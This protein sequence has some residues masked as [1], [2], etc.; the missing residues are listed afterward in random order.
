MTEGKFEKYLITSYSTR[1]FA[2]PGSSDLPVNV[3]CDYYAMMEGE[4]DHWRTKWATDKRYRRRRR[5]RHLAE[6]RLS[7]VGF[8]SRLS[9]GE[10]KEVAKTISAK[11]G[12][13]KIGFVS[14]F[15]PEIGYIPGTRRAIMGFFALRSLF[16]LVH[17][18]RKLGQPVKALELAAGSE[19]RGIRRLDDDAYVAILNDSKS[20][21]RYL[22]ANMQLA[23]LFSPTVKVR[24]ALELEP[25]AFFILRDLDALKEINVLVM[26]NP[27]LR[28]RVF[29]NLDIS[30]WRLAGI[31]PDQLNGKL[32][33]R[34]LHAHISGHH[35][36][37]HFG[38]FPIR[39]TLQTDPNADVEFVPWRKLLENLRQDR[40]SPYEGTLSLELEAV[41]DSQILDRAVK[42]FEELWDGPN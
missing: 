16:R 4:V 32:G 26:K 9:R 42:E 3:G 5:W 1:G 8:L 10:V 28:R 39:D 22:L 20:C 29:F 25:G 30:H 40:D 35:E 14:A 12:S 24:I 33:K 37:A 11:A 38:D 6:T 19:I 2:V 15:L 31:S 23:M 18:L 36:S 7:A 34:I 41:R 21:R 27:V 13:K 17:E